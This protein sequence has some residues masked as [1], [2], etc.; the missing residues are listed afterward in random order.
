MDYKE[1]LENKREQIANSNGELTDEKVYIIP[2]IRE[3]ADAFLQFILRGAI[4]YSDDLC[5]KYSS[6]E[7]FKVW[8]VK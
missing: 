5:L 1:A 8:V 2:E 4:K 7:K 3:E 6:N